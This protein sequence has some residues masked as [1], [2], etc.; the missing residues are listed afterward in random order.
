MSNIIEI[1]NLYK[2]YKNTEYFSV[3]D[4]SLNIEEGEIYGILSSKRCG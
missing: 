3:Q 2:K 1:T 4:V